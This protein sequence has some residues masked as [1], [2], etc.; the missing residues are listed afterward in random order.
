[1]KKREVVE[2]NKKKFNKREAKSALIL[3]M[4]SNKSW[5]R[6]SRYYHCPFCNYWHLTSKDRGEGKI[7]EIKLINE[8]Q[9]LKLLNKDI[10]FL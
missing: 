1:M 3:L 8:D 6:E 10:E 7:Q 9:W 4:N 5:R 2:C